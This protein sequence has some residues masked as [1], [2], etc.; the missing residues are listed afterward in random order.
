MVFRSIIN[1]K[2]TG[3]F[4]AGSSVQ[5]VAIHHEKPDISGIAA[6]GKHWRGKIDKI[7]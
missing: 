4:I 1:L 6:P 2:L 3:V 5:L 7:T